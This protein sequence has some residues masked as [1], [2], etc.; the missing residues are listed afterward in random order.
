M[1]RL[2]QITLREIHL[3]LREPFRISSGVVSMRRIMLLELR[4]AS[5]AVAW[6]EC[7]AGEEP[8]YSS[9]TI[10]TAW[11]AV[12]AYVAPRVL[13]QSFSTPQEVFPALERDFRGHLMAKAGVE[14]GMWGLAA[15]QAGVPLARLI[16][17]VRDQIAVGISMGIQSSPQALA[18]RAMAAIAEGYHKVKIKIEPGRDLAYVRA[19]REALPSA[20]LM[21]DANNAYSLDDAKTLAELDELNLMMIEQPLAHDDLVRHAA[22]QKQLR[23]PLCLDESITSLD[24]AQDMVTLGSGRIINIKPGRVGGFAQS[25]AIHDYCESQGIP[26]WC[27]GMLESGV[28]RAYNVAL[29]SLPNFTMPGDISPSRRYWAQDIVTPEW[30]MNDEGMIAVPLAKPGIGVEIDHER[31]DSLTVRRAVL[32]G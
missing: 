3:P 23:T 1:I 25:I 28:G 2:D 21:A 24:R 32:K 22:L 29:A 12:E 27:G 11:I 16:G 26:V 10:D 18:E 20:E 7:V 19:A 5:G 17:G 9:E 8:N 15:T 30:T 31:V 14:M 13:G 6:S 4:D